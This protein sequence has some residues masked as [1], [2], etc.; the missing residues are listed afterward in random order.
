M[1]SFMYANFYDFLENYPK[2]AVH[3]S[4]PFVDFL[5]KTGHQGL[6]NTLSAISGPL[7]ARKSKAF[8]QIYCKTLRP[9][10]ERSVSRIN[11]QDLYGE[12]D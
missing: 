12:Q 3:R 8:Q 10:R 7:V 9:P 1:Y 11:S 6:R 4:T 5:E 2:T